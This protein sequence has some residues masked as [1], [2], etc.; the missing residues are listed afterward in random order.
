MAPRHFTETVLRDIWTD[1]LKVEDIGVFDNFFDL[2]GHS[3]LAGQVLARVANVFGVSLPIRALF[4]APT[5]EALA[6]RIDEARRDTVVQTGTRNSRGWKKTVPGRC[7]SR[8][9]R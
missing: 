5:V 1:L 6:K 7:P 3:L 2:G 8:R 4:E 9:T